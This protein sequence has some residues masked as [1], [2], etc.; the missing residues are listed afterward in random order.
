MAWS[1]PPAGLPEHELGRAAADVGDQERAGIGTGGELRGRPGERQH[2]FL[3]PGE[4]LGRDA[5]HLLDQ[6]DELGRVVRVPGGAG[7]HHPDRL[8]ARAGDDVRVLAQH[9]HGA[10]ERFRREPAGL[11]HPLAQPD[12]LHPP[13]HVGQ[14]G[15]AGIDVREQQAQRI[16][17]A[18]HGGHP[19]GHVPSPA[20]QCLSTQCSSTQGPDS[21]QAP[22]AASASAPNGFTPA[23]SSWATSACRHFTRSGIPPA[24]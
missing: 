1:R 18:V 8:R 3:V 16:G 11:V 21:H 6:A 12:D 17:A 4:D 5:E 20:T 19:P 15:P 23:T 22:T 2:R 14:P 24:D 13:D 10:G 7:R 9:G